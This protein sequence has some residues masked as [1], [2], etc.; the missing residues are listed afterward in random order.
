M[1]TRFRY[2]ILRLAV[3]AAVIGLG[4][5]I[6][7]AQE[8]THD[9]RAHAVAPAAAA[10]AAAVPA[11]EATDG[12]GCDRVLLTAGRSTVL[13]TPF[14]VTRIALTNPAIADAVVVQ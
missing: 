11:A 7:A 1:S 12:S 8:A 3:N 5:S 4:A 14:D 6:A 9:A 2:S 10:R 13:A